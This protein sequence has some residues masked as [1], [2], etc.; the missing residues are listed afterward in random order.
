MKAAQVSTHTTAS[1]V[2]FR[3]QPTDAR[4]R[5]LAPDDSGQPA[6]EGFAQKTLFLGVLHCLGLVAQLGA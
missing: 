6:F 3:A 1:S 4:V 2:S 5:R